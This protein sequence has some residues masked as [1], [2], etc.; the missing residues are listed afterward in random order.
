MNETE[1]LF[2]NQNKHALCKNKISDEII[3]ESSS[4]STTS[5]TVQ[6]KLK[7]NSLSPR[8]EISSSAKAIR[9]EEKMD[10][11]NEL[12]DA[13]CDFILS[14]SRR[15]FGSSS[16]SSPISC[17]H[18]D[19]TINFGKVF[20]NQKINDGFN[21]NEDSDFKSLATNNSKTSS[22]MSISINKQNTILYNG[23][24]PQYSPLHAGSVPQFSPDIPC[25]TIFIDD[26]IKNQLLMKENLGRETSTS[27]IARDRLRSL[28]DQRDMIEAWAWTCKCVQVSSSVQLKII[29]ISLMIN[30]PERK[31]EKS[32]KF[33]KI[34]N[35]LSKSFEF[36][37]NYCLLKNQSNILKVNK[38]A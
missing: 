34:V 27:R 10:E 22:T 37:C 19:A 25:Q 4:D 38:T 35:F 36:S 7:P 3:G 33:E 8:N 20:K 5:D 23:N 26:C 6:P 17:S 31:R 14:Y 18:N 29:N 32:K 30:F 2:H 13:L 12:P 1:E 24:V 28:I 11:K 21:R 9:K 15:Y 16:S